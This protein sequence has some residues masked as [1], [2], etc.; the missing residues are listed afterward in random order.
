MTDENV[1]DE[2]VTDERRGSVED[3]SKEP[4]D[5][6]DSGSWGAVALALLGILFVL[7]AVAT[8]HSVIVTL[9]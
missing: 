8:A 2:N 5:S 4:T 9:L 7:A 1:T 3:F 6:P